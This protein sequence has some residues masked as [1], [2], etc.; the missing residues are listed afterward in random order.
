[1]SSNERIWVLHPFLIAVFPVLALL[2]ANADQVYLQDAAMPLAMMLLVSLLLWLV[3]WP[4]YR[5]PEKRGLA[6]SLLLGVFWGYGPIIDAVRGL[7]GNSQLLGDLPAPCLALLGLAGLSGP[8]FWLARSRRSL[9]GITV[10]L[11]QAAVCAVLVALSMTGFKAAQYRYY[12]HDAAIGDS[13]EVKALLSHTLPAETPRPNLY[14]VI[15]DAYARADI[16]SSRYHY[17][18]TA[19]VQSLRDR[20]FFVPTKSRSNYMFTWLSL[21]SSLNLDYLPAFRH[22]QDTDASLGAQIQ[23]RFRDNAVFRFLRKQGYRIAVLGSGYALTDHPKADISEHSPWQLR[24]F[25]E[26]VIGITPLRT[27]LHRMGPSVACFCRRSMTLFALDRLP[28]IHEKGG[29]LFAFA[30]I[31]LPHP[32]FVFDDHGR[33]VTPKGTAPMADG[34]PQF[35][36]GLT[37][38]EYIKG[39]T[40]QVTFANTRVLRM[41]DDI[42]RSDPN[43]IIVLQGDHG[44]RLGYSN[45][46]GK[47]DLAEGVGIFLA[48]R[49][50]GKDMGTILYD[51]LSP[52][53][54]FRRVFNTCFGTALSPLPDRSYFCATYHPLETMTD[55]TE[56]LTP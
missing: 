30:H 37:P 44:P 43:G 55:V 3:L 10:F 33:P 34:L 36:A 1:M 29:P 12:A 19:F 9:K 15:L 27:L 17:D 26:A 54:L 45:D 13:P 23:G 50:P 40:R 7:A 21:S 31:V 35:S 49:I 51:G 24:E 53:N 22:G 5:T 2:G 41:V 52:V 38:E 56:R 6:L 20:G 39:Y 8:A 11:N 14:Y 46:I 48:C 42:M 16:L 47:A 4:L 28:K 25:H 32:P 18:N